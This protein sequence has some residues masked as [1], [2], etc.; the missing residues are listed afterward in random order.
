MIW[1]EWQFF[2]LP[3]EGGGL[4]DQPAGLLRRIRE[5]LE[6]YNAVL[7][8][9]KD[10]RQAGQMAAWKNAHPREARIIRRIKELRKADG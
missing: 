10:G 1:D 7:L 4:N 5:A 9:N 8:Y 6:V 3:P 2:N